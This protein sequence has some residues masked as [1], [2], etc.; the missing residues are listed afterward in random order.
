[1]SLHHHL[2]PSRER[3]ALH[4]LNSFGTLVPEYVETRSLY[5]AIQPDMEQ[6][7]ALKFLRGI[8]LRGALS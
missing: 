2:G 3:L 5:T 6:V 4:V 1:M 7:S 8:K